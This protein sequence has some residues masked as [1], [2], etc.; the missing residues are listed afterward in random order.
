MLYKPPNTA[1]QTVVMVTCN[2]IHCAPQGRSEMRLKLNTT[3]LR[4]ALL[5]HS[6]SRG[7]M[8]TLRLQSPRSAA[9]Y[10]VVTYCKTQISASRNSK[11]A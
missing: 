2:K 10:R 11:G 4:E 8:Q 1:G 5:A 9:V 6:N 7:T 3:A